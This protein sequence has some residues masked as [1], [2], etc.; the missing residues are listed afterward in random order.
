MKANLLYRVKPYRGHSTY[1]F[2]VRANVAGKWQRKY[3]ATAGEAK[4]Y[5]QQKNN[6]V[7]NL[8]LESIEFPTWLR[9]MAHECHAKLHPLGKTIKDATEHFTEFVKATQNSCTAAD[10]VREIIEN[11]E[12]DGASQRYIE[13]L[14]SRLNRFAKDFNGEPVAAITAAQIDDWLRGLRNEEAKPLLSTTRNNFRRVLIVAFN[15]AVQRGYA[16]A[17]VAERT[18]KAKVVDESPGIFSVEETRRLLESAAEV[19]PHVLPYLVIGCFAGLRPA[20]LARLE[21]ENIDF[22]AG[23]IEVTAKKA[24]TARRRFVKM[25]DNLMAWLIPYRLR[26][27]A[28]TPRTL[29]RPLRAVRTHAKLKKWPANALRHSF[30]SYHLAHFQDAAKLALEMGHTDS[31]MIFEHYRQLVK[32]KEAARYWKITPSSSAELGEKIVAMA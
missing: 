21:W 8:G 11:R 14:K 3:F 22:D 31:N 29:R 9:V 24:K 18:A 4:T 27:G 13:D 16:T 5:A 1:K 23:L 15:Y 28:V 26:K 19:S 12:A 25:Q 20:E 17:N 30:A 32:P 2:L 10:L 7:Q 6:E